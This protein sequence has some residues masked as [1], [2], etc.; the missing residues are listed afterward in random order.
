MFGR[1]KYWSGEDIFL[2]LF[3]S[4]FLIL[5][6]FLVSFIVFVAGTS[7]YKLTGIPC[8]QEASMVGAQEYR[9]TISN[10]CWF[11]IDGVMVPSESIVP[12]EKDGKLVYVSK[13]VVRSQNQINLNTTTGK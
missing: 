2:F 1:V 7:L 12:V 5:V 3:G 10:G 13:Y 9:Y 11:K 8:A 6:V 4:T